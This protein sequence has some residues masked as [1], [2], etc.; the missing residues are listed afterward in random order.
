ME[1]DV[2][3]RVLEER[4][5]SV[6]DKLDLIYQQTSK[7]NGR[8]NDLEDWKT[9]IEAKINMSKFWLTGIGFVVGFIIEKIFT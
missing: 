1:N 8:V 3:V 5:K 4:I 9:G 6:T 7:T 2:L